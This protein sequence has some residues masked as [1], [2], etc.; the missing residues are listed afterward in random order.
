MDATKSTG[1]IF[2]VIAAVL[3]TMG[4]GGAGSNHSAPAPAATALVIN[5]RN[6]VAGTAVLTLRCD[7]PGGTLQDPAAVCARLSHTPP[8]V[9]LHPRAFRCP[10]GPL[11][12]WD[13]SIRGH[14]GDQR[15]HVDLATCVTPQ[16]RLFRLLGISP[17]Q[18]VRAVDADR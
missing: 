5:A 1:A 2:A 13:V 3:T 15:V 16:I 18:L 14:A 8:R 9:L 7:P 6:T 4:C 17:Q 12:P 10:G 11:A